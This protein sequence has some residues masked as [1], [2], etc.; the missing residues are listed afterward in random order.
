[1]VRLSFSSLILS[2]ETSLGW[3]STSSAGRN[4]IIMSVSPELA[5]AAAA[6][7]KDKALE[8]QTKELLYLREQLR[9]S[10]EIEITGKMGHPVYCRGSF[11]DGNFRETGGGILSATSV[12]W[13]VKMECTDSYCDG[14]PLRNFWQD[15]E[16]RVG[17]MVYGTTSEVIGPRCR[18]RAASS[19]KRA[20][21]V[22]PI[23]P[24]SLRM[25][26]MEINFRSLPEG[27]WK[28]LQSCDAFNRQS[29]DISSRE[30]IFHKFSHPTQIPQRFPNQR[31]DVSSICFH[32]LE[33][34]KLIKTV[35]R[36]AEFERLKAEKISKLE[37]RRDDLIFDR[38]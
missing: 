11:Q 2:S 15:M 27:P 8:E 3:G 5:L 7:I 38:I 35:K 18:V 29:A 21:V 37:K 19:T 24:A 14:I 20:D 16:I 13:E 23:S 10:Q 28:H 12:F 31:A 25:L 33:V 4:T 26:L 6:A 1:M 22:C 9:S 34:L 32:G 30:N 17:G 36:D